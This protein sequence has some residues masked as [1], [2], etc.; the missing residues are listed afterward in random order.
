MFASWAMLVELGATEINWEERRRRS[1]PSASVS[2][3]PGPLVGNSYCYPVCRT[4]SI[5]MEQIDINVFYFFPSNWKKKDKL[6]TIGKWGGKMAAGG[7]FREHGWYCRERKTL[8]C[9][10]VKCCSFKAAVI[11]HWKFCNYELGCLIKISCSEI[12]TYLLC[13]WNAAYL[14]YICHHGIGTT[15]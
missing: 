15:S 5:I 9:G 3:W 14:K 13:I 12:T 2:P 1:W 11:L 8:P 4:K 6:W 10:W 7:G